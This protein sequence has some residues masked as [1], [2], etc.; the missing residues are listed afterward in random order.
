MIEA[1]SQVST[2]GDKGSVCSSLL[3]QLLRPYTIG[4]NSLSRC[5]PEF[6]PA[7]QIEHASGLASSTPS[8]LA[9]D[10]SAG[11]KPRLMKAASGH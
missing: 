3:R 5:L 8:A 7:E 11:P 1:T 9:T 10:A 6:G 4:K 2:F